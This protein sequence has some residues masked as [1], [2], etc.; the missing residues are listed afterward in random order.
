M[1]L[2]AS[3]IYFTDPQPSASGK[4]QVWFVMAEGGGQLGEIKWFGRWR[5]YA[6]FPLAGTV[7]EETCLHELAAFCRSQTANRPRPARS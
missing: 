2:Q 7:F 1:T 4:T 5:R 3:Y 6:F